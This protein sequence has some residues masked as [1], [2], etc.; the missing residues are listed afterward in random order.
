MKNENENET[1]IITW[2]TKESFFYKMIN[3][4]LRVGDVIKIFFIRIGI[5]LLYS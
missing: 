4:T 1:E 3:E 2:Y 5:Y